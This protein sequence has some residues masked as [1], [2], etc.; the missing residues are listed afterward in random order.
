MQSYL[1]EQTEEVPNEEE[2]G[3]EERLAKLKPKKFEKVNKNLKT[4]AK[5]TTRADK[6]HRDCKEAFDV[7]RR[8]KCSLNG[9]ER[10]AKRLLEKMQEMLDNVMSGVAKEI[11]MLVKEFQRME[12]EIAKRAE[13]LKKE[14]E[15]EFKS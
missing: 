4:N 1:R 3:L 12:G 6:L 15:E 13:E 7:E 14:A 8:G 2:G 11:H 9:V 10:A 5:I